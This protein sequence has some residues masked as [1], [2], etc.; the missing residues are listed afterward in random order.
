MLTAPKYAPPQIHYVT[1]DGSVVP[2]DGEMLPLIADA[3]RTEVLLDAVRRLAAAASLSTIREGAFHLPDDVFL[4]RG[5]AV[6]RA[7]IMRML[8]GAP[9]YLAFVADRRGRPNFYRVDFPASRHLQR[10]SA[11]SHQLAA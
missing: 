3:D 7:E 9:H 8:S 4:G 11:V 6:G 10:N 2:R 1:A 5:W